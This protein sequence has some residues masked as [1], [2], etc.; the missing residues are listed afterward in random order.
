MPN[1]K[2]LAEK[3]AMVAALAEKMKNAS[4]GVIVDYKGITVEQDTKLRAE[5][6][7]NGV[8]YAVVKNTLTRF[9][10]KQ[11][12]FDEL[13]EVLNGTTALAVSA[14]DS[15]MPA[16]LISEFAKKN[17]KVFK[18]KAGFVDGKV[19]DVATIERIGEL[20][21]KDVLLAM[22]LGTMNA[23]IAALARALNAIAEKNGEGAPAPEEK[24]AEEAAPA[25]EA[26]AEEPA[27][28]AEAAPAEETAA[29]AEE[30]AA[31]APSAE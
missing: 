5:L 10:A 9:A 13:D 22:V 29:P 7:K 25:A 23:P 26:A 21:S 3:Q 6:R 24:P 16:K 28:P 27:A 18:I 20:P 1:A 8:D 11:I 12:G 19:V 30:S 2:V 17:P 14:E 15:V 4:S 31:E